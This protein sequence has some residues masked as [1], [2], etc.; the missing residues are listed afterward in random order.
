MAT[1]KTILSEPGEWDLS[2][3]DPRGLTSG[4]LRWS[5]QSLWNFGYKHLGAMFSLGSGVGLY[6]DGV[7]AKGYDRLF[8]AS[9]D[10]AKVGYSGGRATSW[11]LDAHGAPAIMGNGWLGDI[12]IKNGKF[13]GPPFVMITGP[14]W[15]TFNAKPDGPYPGIESAL[16]ENV[17]WDGF[18]GLCIMVYKHGDITFRGCRGIRSQNT[19]EFLV[20]FYKKFG[21]TPDSDKI[22]M[23]TTGAAISI[24]LSAFNVG[25]DPYHSAING[26]MTVE[27]CSIEMFVN[28]RTPTPSKY[29]IDQE[30]HAVQCRSAKLLI[31]MDCE[32]N[33]VLDLS[34]IV[35]SWAEAAK[36]GFMG[37][38]LVYGKVDILMVR[39]KGTNCGGPGDGPL[40]ALKPGGGKVLD[41]EIIRDR[42]KVPEPYRTKLDQFSNVTDRNGLLKTK[43]GDV[44]DPNLA[45]LGL[46]ATDRD[47][48]PSEI[49]GF[50]VRGCEEP[51]DGWENLV[52]RWGSHVVMATEMEVY[53]LDGTLLWSN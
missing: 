23:G 7:S 37:C 50:T 27:D 53:D 2:E 44:A 16:F 6:L 28:D 47:G 39:V 22:L 30:W 42:S 48:N 25:R 38:E 32:F 21:W 35:V 11:N 12:T 46:N 19:A 1:G 14:W 3:V 49:M 10:Y 51:L 40:L 26:N 41:C 34:Y 8:Y 29:D 45:M 17:T 52:W 4:V 33:N 18:G 31:V 15:E 43:K 24:Y 5:G 13:E 9:E 20:P 36:S